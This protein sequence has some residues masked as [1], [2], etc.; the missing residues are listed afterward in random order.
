VAG[1]PTFHVALWASTAVAFRL[2]GGEI[3]ESMQ[4]QRIRILDLV[5]LPPA[6][7]WKSRSSID[8]Q[9]ARAAGIRRYLWAFSTLSFQI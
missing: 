8:P 1:G 7:S 3:S 4:Q 5:H 9:S 2:H 6:T